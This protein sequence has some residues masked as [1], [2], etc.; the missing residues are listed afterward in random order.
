MDERQI[1]IVSGLPRSGTSMLMKMLEAGGM[2]VLTDYIREAD[3][4]NPEGYY[5]FEKVKQIKHDESW[6]E[7]AE[8][9]VVK[10][11]SQLLQH[12]PPDYTYKVVFMH[13][14]M[15]E[16]L[17]SQRKMLIRRGAPSDE[18][19]DEQMAALF[20]KHLKRLKTWL[21]E[22]PNFEVIYVSYN[23]VLANPIE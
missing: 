10:M 1:A 13:R 14:R 22:Q 9:K 20:R 23:E 19:S 2:Q 15:E 6:L 21:D 16:I 11:I 17:A 4:D 12:L 3:E 7:D 5:E 18:V 8:G